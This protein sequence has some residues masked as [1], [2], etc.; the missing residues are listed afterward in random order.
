[1]PVGIG[2]LIATKLLGLAGAAATAAAI[3]INIAVAYGIGLLY[4][5]LGP[6]LETDSSARHT[7]RGEVVNARWV[8]G[9]A[10]VPGVL[11]YWGSHEREARMGLILSE[12]EC[13]KIEDQMWI[14]GHAVKLSRA[15]DATG[16]LLTPVFSS[17]YHGKIE[18]REYFKAEGTQGTHMR[19]VPPPADT[20]YEQ[21][22]GSWALA[23]DHFTEVQRTQGLTE[24]QPFVTPFPAWTAEHKLSGVSWVYVKLTQ[25]VY[26]QDLEQRFWSGVSNLEFLVK[27]IKITWPG[28][29][30]PTWTDNP[31]ALRYWWETERRGRE[32][33]DIH[34]GDFSA[35]FTVCNQ[36]IDLTGLPTEYAAYRG[37]P[38]RY[39]LNGVVT[40]GDDV[41]QVEDQLDAAW[42]GE[43]IEV[44]GKLRF[45]PGVDHPVAV[46]SITDAD[47]IEPPVVAPWA[48]LQD[49]VNAVNAEIPQSKHHEWTKLG[50]PQYTDEAALARDGV[51]RPGSIQLTFVHDPIAAGRLQAVLLR[52]SRES[53]RLELAVTPGEAFE[54]VALVPTDRVQ[55]TSSE[56]GLTASRMEVERVTVREDWSVALTLREDLDD[57][58]DNTLVLPPLE[59]RIIR[60]P[61]HTIGPPVTG[62]AADEI[63]EVAKDG[64]IVAYLLLTWNAAAVRN[65]GGGVREKPAAGATSEPAW[66]S[67]SS[68]SN[69]F[70]YSGITIGKTYQIRARHWSQRGV[71]GDW[72]AMIEHTVGGDLDPPGSPTDLSVTA[73]PGG[74]S[75]AWANPGDADLKGTQVWISNTNQMADASQISFERG[76]IFSLW[77]LSQGAT[78]YVWIRAEDR[79]GNRSAFV[80]PENG[81][82]LA[83]GKDGTG[84]EFIFRRTA[85]E[86]TPDTPRGGAHQDE[87][88][89]PVAVG[90]EP[91]T[92][93]PSGVTADL[94]IEWTSARTG[95]TG[96]WGSWSGPGVFARYSLDGVDGATVEFIFRRTAT[97]TKPG[98]PRG[99]EHEDE[100]LPTVTVGEP[101]TDDPS[102]PTEALP[103]EWVSSR[104]GMSENWIGWSPATLWSRYAQDGEQGIQGSPGGKGL[105]GD[106]GPK[107][108]PGVQ[109]AAGTPG[110]DGDQVFVY[111]TNAP[112]DTDPTTLVPLVRLANGDWTTDSGYYWYA[113]ATRIPAD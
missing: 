112:Q 82:A 24:T 1:M 95:S 77:G 105:F 11:F 53:L 94:S 25:P 54:R 68:P 27:G 47:I 7:I 113:D 48:P 81:T 37:T 51:L 72:S 41:G 10:R 2:T 3:G 85:T 13:E 62:L 84:W 19:Q 57:T 106:I 44:G 64:T 9:R 83:L 38:A 36:P 71:A 23:P 12:G 8:L 88:L 90:E 107:G 28:Q 110:A 15:T 30:T 59:P 99:G 35:A 56:F 69:S 75:V 49:R 73:T 50:L 61:D 31:A 79:S 109:G 76:E 6:D 104:S 103:Y 97:E 111:Y 20:E 93:E 45:R 22:D 14:D 96:Q 66:E 86:T 52:K 34:T 101:W 42:A 18:I 102:G 78:K 67:G 92:D 89:P 4:R 16:D 98:T 29:T 17:K 40:A 39:T 21:E 5:L 87:Y 58:Y 65:T 55:L 32:A 70:R 46:L 43:V 91:W 33:G 74:V 26:G 108:N 63:A 100:H 80:G 60:L